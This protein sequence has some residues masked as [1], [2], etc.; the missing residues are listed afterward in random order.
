MPPKERSTTSNPKKVSKTS[1]NVQAQITELQCQVR[2]LTQNLEITYGVIQCMENAISKL[3]T[4]GEDHHSQVIE[5]IESLASDLPNRPEPDAPT[6]TNMNPTLKQAKIIPAPRKYKVMDGERRAFKRAVRKPLIIKYVIK[7]DDPEMDEIEA[8][9][10]YST[11][12]K[13][14]TTVLAA[15]I[16]HLQERWRQYD[17]QQA[18]SHDEQQVYNND[19]QQVDSNSDR[20]VDSD[21]ENTDENSDGSSSEDERHTRRMA[22]ASFESSAC[23]KSGI[24]LSI[25]E[26][27]WAAKH[28]LSEGWNNLKK[29]GSKERRPGKRALS[30]SDSNDQQRQ[31]SKRLHQGNE[32]D[33]NIRNEALQINH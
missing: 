21:D 1:S 19:E 13:E 10:L 33:D 16:Q 30:D 5:A 25:C 32:D 29:K 20:Q 15:L 2:E 18:D 12:L 8:Q 26:R 27:H 14:R 17:E 24:D 23:E 11:I 6:V 22:V 7:H 4:R 9:G 28:F 3:V 31:S